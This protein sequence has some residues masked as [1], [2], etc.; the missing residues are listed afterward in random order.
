MNGRHLGHLDSGR[1]LQIK[2]KGMYRKNETWDVSDGQKGEVSSCSLS[3]SKLMGLVHSE[4]V[5]IVNF[6]NFGPLKSCRGGLMVARRS[7]YERPLE[8]S[9]GGFIQATRQGVT[10][11]H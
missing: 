8:R 9:Y 11:G 2:S 10:L 3:V 1:A 5:E 6:D 7:H 4:I